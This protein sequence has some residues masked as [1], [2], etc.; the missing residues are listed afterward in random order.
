MASHELTIEEMDRSELERAYEDLVMDVGNYQD[1]VDR[2]LLEL[3]F[4]IARTKAE[5]YKW[6]GHC[7]SNK[8]HRLQ[9]ERFDDTWKIYCNAWSRCDKIYEAYKARAE[10]IKKQ[11]EEMK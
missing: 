7:Y 1:E 6:L 5:L 10:K 9:K 8:G 3:R 11:L 4:E 2:K